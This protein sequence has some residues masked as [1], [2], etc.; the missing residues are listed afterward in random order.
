VSAVRTGGNGLPPSAA[1]LAADCRPFAHKPL[2]ALLFAFKFNIHGLGAPKPDRHG[3][4][5]SLPCICKMQ[6]S[7][8]D[9]Q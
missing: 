6:L 7:C 4:H 2:E 8:Q 5:V 9:R 1:A 3:Q